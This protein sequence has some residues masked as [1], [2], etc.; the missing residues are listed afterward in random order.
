MK[1]NMHTRPFAITGVRILQSTGILFANINASSLD[2]I[3]YKSVG[4]LT[5]T[6]E[7]KN[8]DRLHGQT[9]LSIFRVIYLRNDARN[10]SEAGCK[11]NRIKSLDLILTLE[12]F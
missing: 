2:D 6:T 5:P 10:L 7:E 9:T 11:A 8:E 3:G 4:Y 12:M 1:H